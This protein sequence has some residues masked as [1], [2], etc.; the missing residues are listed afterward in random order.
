MTGF[1]RIKIIDFGTAKIYEQNKS[2][3]KIIGSS[4]YI[5][6]EVLHK[7]YNEKCDIWSVGVILYILLCG[8]APFTGHNHNEILSKIKIGNYDLK[9]KPFDSISIEAKDLIKKMLRNEC[10]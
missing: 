6:P 5:A 1:Y 9:R 4:Y 7:N 10:K 2:E 8:R 3:N